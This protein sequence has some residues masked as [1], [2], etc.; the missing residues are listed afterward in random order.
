MVAQQPQIAQLG[1][2]RHV[3]PV[4]LDIVLRIGRLLLKVGLQLIDLDRLETKDRDIKA[5]RF[6]QPGQLWYFDRKAL[7]IPARILRNPV[8]RNRKRALFRRR[9]PRDHDDRHLREAE[10]LRGLVAALAGDECPV[11]T[12]QQWVDEAERDHA[13]CDLAD[14]FGG[15]SP[16][17]M[18]VALDLTDRQRLHPHIRGLELAWHALPLRSLSAIRPPP[19][20]RVNSHVHSLSRLIWSPQAMPA[21]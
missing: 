6:Q 9:K 17:I 3:K 20:A 10:E 7:T 2:R 4:G 16:G 18:P 13:V 1:D 8:V 15:M 19:P 11:F 21:K 12:Y 5:V 14:L